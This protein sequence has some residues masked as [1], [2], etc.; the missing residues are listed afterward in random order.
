M[1]S[2]QSNK[3]R[4]QPKLALLLARVVLILMLYVTVRQ[5]RSMPP[6]IRAVARTSLRRFQAGAQECSVVPLTSVF[7]RQVLTLPLANK[8][9]ADQL[10]AQPLA[11]QHAVYT[12]CIML[13]KEWLTLDMKVQ[14]TVW[15]FAGTAK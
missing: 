4:C 8:A 2:C 9:A 3:Q 1:T 14:H 5:T 10:G 12:G 7:T 15:I 6:R 11:Q 13:A